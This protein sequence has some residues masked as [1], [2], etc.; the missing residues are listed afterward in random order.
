M[1]SVCR[2]RLLAVS[3]RPGASARRGARL[4]RGAWLALWALVAASS[5][6]VAAG[7]A[8]ADVFDT[9]SINLIAISAGTYHTCAVTDSGG[10]KCWGGNTYGMLGN[11]TTTLSFTPV[12]VTGLTSGVTAISTS[13]AATHTCALT[14]TGGVKCWGQNTYGQLGDGTTVDRHTPVNVSGLATGVVAISVGAH[15]TCALTNAGGIKCWGQNSN[16]QLGNGTTTDSPTPVDVVNL[17][18]VRAISAGGAYHACALLTSTGGIKCWGDDRFGQLGQPNN[19]FAIPTA[20]PIPGDVA[21]L[22]SGVTAIS[23][24]LWHT[25]ALTSSAG[26]K[27]W[28]YNAQ[29]QLGNGTLTSSTSPVAVTGLASGVTAISAG[30]YHNC[31]VTTSGGAKC[32]GFN[33]AGQLG[34]GTTTASRTPVDVIGLTSG[35]TLIS[36]GSAHTCALTATSG[37]CWGANDRGQLGNGTTTDSLTPLNVISSA[38]VDAPPPADATAPTIAFTQSPATS[39]WFTAAPA[40]VTVTATD[41]D[42]AG[43]ASLACTLD[44]NAVALTS[45]GST[46]TTRYGQATT[47]TDGNHAVACQAADATGNT[48]S[49]AAHQTHLKLDAT[50]PSITGA[51]LTS[52][53]GNGWYNGPVTV[54][55]TCN[56]ATS[57]VATCPADSV[58]SSQGLNQAVTGTATDNAGNTARFTVSGINVDMT[59]PTISFSNNQS[60]YSVD[61]TITI[62]C[63]AVDN[64]SGLATSTCASVDTA[65]YNYPIG[66]ST[67]S[68]TASDNAG[69]GATASTSFTVRVSFSSLC[70][71]TRRFS[72]NAGVALGLC[73]KLNAADASV[74]SG[75]QNAKAGEI[76][77]YQNQ[78]AAQSGKAI[79]VTNAAILSE[80]ASHV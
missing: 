27:C 33:I 36:A 6:L 63:T 66:T 67:L 39:G 10:A 5:P 29:G 32:W 79:S 17:P 68:A 11:G 58:I 24:G 52:P 12:D 9:G 34:N 44:G 53:N 64:L 19:G 3:L 65:A 14:S 21:G 51:A 70:N 35:V 26:V 30:Y 20:S 18:S 54:H 69:N 50:A 48:A 76:G 72:S 8:A 57:G 16:G 28:G 22:T 74:A 23:V 37:K 78:V 7:P 15:H 2:R 4:R 13:S 49:Y 73:A 1:R 43:V 80:L 56:D 59:P 25:C 77:A 55:F 41:S 42:G 46:A 38:P 40:A 71:L 62:G 45:P 60:T 31:V 61:S 47:S 75:D